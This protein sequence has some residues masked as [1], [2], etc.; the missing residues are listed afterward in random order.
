MGTLMKAFLE[1][2]G[3]GMRGDEPGAC[4]YDSATVEWADRQRGLGFATDYLN[5]HVDERE[6]E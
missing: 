5:T 3:A 2:W 1:G 6:W 4:P